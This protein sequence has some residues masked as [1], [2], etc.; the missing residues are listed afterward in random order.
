MTFKLCIL[1][2]LSKHTQQINSQR[3]KNRKVSSQFDGSGKQ[4]EDT[5]TYIGRRQVEFSAEILRAGAALLLLQH[6]E[7]L[8]RLLISPLNRKPAKRS[9]TRKARETWQYIA[10]CRRFGKLS[11]ATQC[12]LHS[13]KVFM[14]LLCACVLGN[15][16]K[17]GYTK[18]LMTHL[19]SGKWQ[20]ICCYLFEVNILNKSLKNVE[21]RMLEK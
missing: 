18:Y 7:P 4:T 19:G 12:K 13:S 15:Q 16:A 11:V 9:R 5:H 6:L 3:R 20:H 8:L 2:Q 1:T 21:T 14:C 10:K 17:V